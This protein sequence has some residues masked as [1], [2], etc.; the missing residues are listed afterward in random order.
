MERR[1]AGPAA[2]LSSVREAFRAQL[3]ERRL[4]LAELETH[5]GEHAISLRE[6][7]PVAVGWSRSV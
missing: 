7:D 2:L 3:A 6:L 5:A 4:G 1:A